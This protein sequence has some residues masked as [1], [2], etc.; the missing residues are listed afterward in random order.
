[1]K[2]ALTDLLN[3]PERERERRGLLHTPAEIYGQVELWEN[4]CTIVKEKHERIRTFLGEFLRAEKKQ[5]V[6]TGAGTSEFIGYC[7]EG[8]LRRHLEIP[9]NVVSSTS[10]VTNPENIF[11]KDYSTL[12]VSFARSGNSPESLGAVEIAD[13]TSKRVWHLVV[14]CNE[15]GALARWAHGMGS[16]HGPAARRD[17]APSDGGRNPEGVRNAFV[18]CLDGRTDDKGLAMT[19]SFS[20]MVV[21][22]QLLAHTFDFTGCDARVR[23]TIEAGKTLLELA[24]DAAQGLCGLDFHR[25]VFLGS[26]PHYG[27]AIESHLKLQELTA[28]RIMCGFDTF[29][30]LRHG[31]Q[32]LID[33]R[34]LVIAYISK[35]LYRRKY[36]SDLLKELREKK[37]GLRTAACGPALDDRTRSLV[38]FSIDFD[39]GGKL[40]LDDD[41]APPVSVI[42]G[43]LLGLFKSV[44]MGL[45]PDAPSEA[46]VINRVVKG[47]KVYNP[48]EYRKTGRFEIIAGE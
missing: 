32:A 35:D 38:D 45:K 11:L 48:I 41:H 42:L 21:A 4:T 44:G 10:L 6:C 25:A 16:V 28:G 15:G 18:L 19:A 3:L 33:G 2:N 27:T 20:N 46:G 37:L 5:V 40:G 39:P 29:M 47:V 8:L 22:G 7:I 13:M 24:P 34:T 9:V 31:P 17:D 1:M 36:E 43:Q 30:G 14:T 26:G 12:L 23:K